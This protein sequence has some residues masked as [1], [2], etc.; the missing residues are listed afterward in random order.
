MCCK[1]TES[2]TLLLLTFAVVAAGIVE[3]TSAANYS[4]LLVVSVIK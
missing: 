3:K 1:V 2:S 4:S